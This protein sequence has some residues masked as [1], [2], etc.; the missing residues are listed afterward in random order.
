MAIEP[1]INKHLQKRR[2]ALA[3]KHFNLMLAGIGVTSSFC[4]QFYGGYFGAGFGIAI[5]GAA[6]GL[7]TLKT[8]YQM[9]G[10]PELAGV[11]SAVRVFTLSSRHTTDSVN[12]VL[13]LLGTRRQCR[14]WL[15]WCLLCPAAACPDY[16]RH[17]HRH[18]RRCCSRHPLTYATE[19]KNA[20]IP[21][22]F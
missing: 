13:W 10:S 2:K 19:I 16:P 15:R 7:T 22:L 17:R 11:A 14:R 1:F 4:W 5:L 8:I 21:L 12:W 18:R 20:T 3:R 6:W 9:N